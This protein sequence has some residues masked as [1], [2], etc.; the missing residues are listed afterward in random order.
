MIYSGGCTIDSPA[1]A[2]AH[3]VARL[4]S[5]GATSTVT[6]FANRTVDAPFA[7]FDAGIT[8]HTGAPDVMTVSTKDF[9]KGCQYKLSPDL[10]GGWA[11]GQARKLSTLS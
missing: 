8:G 3:S 5:E 11:G 6:K 2:N 9:G 1:F 10:T 7:L 4:T